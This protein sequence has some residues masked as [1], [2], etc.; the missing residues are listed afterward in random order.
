MESMVAMFL[1]TIAIVSLMA[2]QP[3]SW[4]SAGKANQLGRASG[5]MQTELESI[6]NDIMR[7]TIPANKINVEENA[8][9]ARYIV[10][11]TITNPATN[12][13]LVHVSVN[14][15][16]NST[17]IKSSMI[18]TRQMGFNVNDKF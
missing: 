2:M 16:G 5:I 1:T 18:V 6:E 11:T 14:W 15:T 9:S 10:N 8:G 3:L 7:G 12:R 4:Q 17:G 13:W